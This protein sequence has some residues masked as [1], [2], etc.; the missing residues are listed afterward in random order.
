MTTSSARTLG[1]RQT[2][3]AAG[4]VKLVHRITLAMLATLLAVVALVAVSLYLSVERGFS[5][6]VRSLEEARLAPA[7]R[8]LEA[9]YQ[10]DGTWERIARQPQAFA[11]L[12]RAEDEPT[13][14]RDTRPDGEDEPAALAPRP[15]AR[16]D[17]P[18]A[19]RPPPTPPPRR[20]PP[21]RPSFGPAESSPPPPPD[22]SGRDPLELPPRVTLYDVDGHALVGHGVLDEATSRLRLTSKGATVGWL[23]V[24]A[25]T[26]YDD[27]LDRDYIAQVRVHVAVIAMIA[28]ALGL[29]TGWTTTRRLLR[30]IDALSKGARRLACGDYHVQI[31]LDRRDELGQLTR[32]FD[33]LAVTLADNE[34]SRRQWVADT[35]HELRTPITVLRAEVDCILDG[36]QPPDRAA[37]QSLQVEIARLDMLVSDLD[38]LA[39]SDRG[40]LGVVCTPI[41]AVEALREAVAAF[42]GRF[43]RHGIGLAF[44][45]EAAEDT[46]ILGDEAR[47]KQV[48]VNLLENSL[49]YTDEGG[50]LQVSA[51][52]DGGHVLL[53]FDDSAPGVSEEALLHLF[54]RFYRAD[55]SRSRAHGGAGLGL[56]ICERI[57]AA[58]GGTIRATSSPLGGVRIDVKLLRSPGGSARAVSI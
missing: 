10:I 44:D 19:G 49:R 48:F 5:R 23:G 9:I 57:V 6:Y 7:I 27:E 11:R 42:R 16:G 30:P 45:V 34:R 38:Q 54:D 33:A 1:A 4:S 29:L 40:T 12:L 51:I 18:P 43:T 50:R 37:L 35:S 3:R 47:L 53:R 39:Q 17:E 20:P 58:H 21:P 26:K 31:G 13:P 41:S 24:Q 52:P 56:S 36:L 22:P 25:I 8:R 32:D 55:P 46:A 15:P 14:P 28:L 2:S